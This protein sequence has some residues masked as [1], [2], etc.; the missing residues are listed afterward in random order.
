MIER[1]SDRFL[2]FGFIS[3]DGRFINQACRT[4]STGFLFYAVNKLLDIR[5]SRE[6]F[7]LAALGD[8][9]RG[10]LLKA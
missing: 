10:S 7:G 2:R 1:I 3:Q 9:K 8:D 4:F 6:N 5:N